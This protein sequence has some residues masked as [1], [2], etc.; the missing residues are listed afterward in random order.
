MST[1]R[2]RLEHRRRSPWRVVLVIVGAV[3]VALG[4]AAAVA[5]LALPPV[6]AETP[7]ERFGATTLARVHDDTASASVELS[8]GWLA[9]GVGPFLPT[10][11]ARLVSPDGAYRLELALLPTAEASVD[12]LLALLDEQGLTDAVA[13]AAW[14]TEGLTS[15]SSVRYTTVEQGEESMT[16]AVVTT[17]DVPASRLVILATTDLTDAARYRTVTADLVGSAVVARTEKPAS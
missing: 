16:V 8:A 1:T 13:A 9:I 6:L 5:V 17:P 12:P 3:V 2:D 4:V 10:D 15:G 11:R 7:R 14:S